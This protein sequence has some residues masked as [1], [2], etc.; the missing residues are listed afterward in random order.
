[1]EQL[2]AEPQVGAQVGAS[3]TFFSPPPTPHSTS[4]LTRQPQDSVVQATEGWRC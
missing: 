4:F 3:K 1:M 2:R